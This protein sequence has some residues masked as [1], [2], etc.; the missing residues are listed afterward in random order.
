MG[1]FPS[2]HDCGTQELFAFKVIK[3]EY[4]LLSNVVPDQELISHLQA[5]YDHAKQEFSL[6]PAECRHPA[7][8]LVK[9]D[10]GGSESINN[11]K[12]MVSD[13]LLQ[14]EKTKKK[15][16]ESDYSKGFS[17]TAADTKAEKE[18]EKMMR[19]G[20]GDESDIEEYT[21]FPVLAPPL[22][23]YREEEMALRAAGPWCRVLTSN[24][25]FMYCHSLTRAI[26]SLRPDDYVDED[27]KGVLLAEEAPVD[28]ANGLFSCHITELPTCLDKLRDQGETKTFLILDGTE[29]HQTLTFYSMKAMLEDVSSLVIPYATSGV[30]RTDVMERCRAKLVGALK[31]GSTFVLYLGGVTIEHADFKSKLCKKDTMPSEVF[32]EGG[33]K[34][35]APKS[36]PRYKLLYRPQDLDSGSGNAIARESFRFMCV[37]TLSPFE[38]EEKLQESIPLGYMRTIYVHN[39]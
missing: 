12:T 14:K 27:I 3:K 19:E 39:N 30:K 25:C 20:G 26:V 36:N 8:I 16:V 35:F 13:A 10:E 18:F 31:S 4:S 32:Q 21:L 1:G 29:D 5:L 24:G 7:C 11:F 15:V 37:S 38:Y 28:P 2:S 22:L 9:L 17:G 6:T 34:L 33:A 23:K